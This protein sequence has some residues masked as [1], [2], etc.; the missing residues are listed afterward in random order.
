MKRA[1]EIAFNKVLNKG[2]VFINFPAML[3]MFGL[4]WLSYHLYKIQFISTPIHI[5]GCVISFFIGW[6]FWSLCIAKWRIWAFEE[7]D[8]TFHHQLKKEAIKAKLIWPDGHFFEK[9]EIRTKAQKAKIKAIH[10]RIEELN[11]N[12]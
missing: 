4:M 12:Q 9:T 10:K 3:L 2:Q 5:I 7:I 8:E 11:T 6:G 1:E